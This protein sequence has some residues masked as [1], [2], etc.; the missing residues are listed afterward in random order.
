[1][2]TKTPIN[3]KLK[4]LNL[5][6]LYP[7]GYAG[8]AAF[9]VHDVCQFLAERGHDIRVLCTEANDSAPYTIR[10]EKVE[11]VVVYRL[12]LPYFRNEDPGGWLLDSTRWKNHVLDTQ[13]AI[14]EI[15]NAWQPDLI[16]YHT[17]HSLIEECLPVFQELKLPIIG[18]AHDA[19]TICLRDSLFRSP[20]GELCSGPATAKC[21]ECVYSHWDGSHARAI[22]KLPWRVAKLGGYP[23][24]R[25]FSRK[26]L[27]EQT[28]GFF[29]Y[30]QFMTDA[31]KGHLKEPVEHISLG[32]DLSELP[33][34]FES[35]PRTLLRFGF[36]AG[37]QE[38][39]GIWDVLDTA[40]SL[41]KK[42]YNFELHIWGPGQTDAPI[43][44]RG[45]KDIVKLR[46]LYKPSELWDVYAEMDVLIMATRVAEAYG[47][48]VQE[49]AAAKVPTIAPRVGGITE[50]MRNGVDGLLYEFL[51]R[52]DL[53]KQMTKILERPQMIAEMVSNLWQVIDTR[54]AVAEIENFYRRILNKK[55][56][57][58]T[59]V[60]SAKG[61]I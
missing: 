30:S 41:K 10:E 2:P 44:E 1:M 25:F 58:Q 51:D 34:P 20:V 31:H 37:F 33:A 5:A 50:Q 52:A 23:A 40:A 12:N 57:R 61:Q 6:E 43:I 29:A 19:W 49:A 21:L 54:D 42:G 26:H 14:N 3:N 32:I 46:G 56:F 18:M 28:D 17:P 4:V 11:D 45:I 9:Y 15:L 35:R 22:A 13:Q 7:P 53:E 47:R 24:H 38:H 36:A 60:E 55:N 16:Q 48:V 27:R 59:N 39:K 8:G